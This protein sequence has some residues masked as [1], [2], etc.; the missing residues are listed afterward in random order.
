MNKSLMVSTVQD[1]HKV[2]QAHA[3]SPLMNPVTFGD[4]KTKTFSQAIFT[5]APGGIPWPWI[6]SNYKVV[7]IHAYCIGATS[8]TF[9]IEERTDP[10]SAGTDLMAS[11]LVATVAQVS[12]DTFSHDVLTPG[13]WLWIG[14]SSKSGSP[15]CLII[16]LE[17]AP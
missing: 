9:N 7:S 3:G 8:V 13:N 10:A 1:V 17:L 12:E 15:T 11:D 2:G 16:T 5:P 4:Q 6:N 14:I